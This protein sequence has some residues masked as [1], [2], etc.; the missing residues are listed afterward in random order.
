MGNWAPDEN[1]FPTKFKAISDYANERNV[2]TLLW[3]EPERI[4]ISDAEYANQPDSE[5]RVK[6]E[7]LIGYGDAQGQLAYGGNGSA[8]QLDLGNKE[9]LDWLCKRVLTILQLFLKGM[10]LLLLFFVLL[11]NLFLHH[12]VAR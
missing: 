7:W 12:P 2:D 6:P 11:P 10:F 5:Y 8:Y 1:R 9:A 4:A 3:F